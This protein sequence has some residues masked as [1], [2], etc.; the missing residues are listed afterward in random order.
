MS[1]GK[2]KGKEQKKMNLETKLC[3]VLILLL[4]I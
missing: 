3:D 4:F 1:R 2:R